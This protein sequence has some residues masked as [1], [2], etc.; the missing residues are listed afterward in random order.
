MA[1]FA[2][3]SKSSASIILFSSSLSALPPRPASPKN[4]LSSLSS[5]CRRSPRC[6]VGVPWGQLTITCHIF[7]ILFIC[8]SPIMLCP[9]V[10]LPGVPDHI[11][12]WPWHR[13]PAA[14][15]GWPAPPVV[16]SPGPPPGRRPACGS[17]TAWR[18]HSPWRGV[19][20]Y[21]NTYNTNNNLFILGRWLLRRVLGLLLDD[22]HH[23]GA[24]HRGLGCLGLELLL[25]LQDLQVLESKGFY[26]LLSSRV[27]ID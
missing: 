9:E 7:I 15:W 10:S 19:F 8:R 21:L 5:W 2:S 24:R 13:G 14:P 22:L 17:R 11:W 6:R 16:P 26:I 23:A 25:A 3:K 4:S 18:S 1:R 20:R 12:G 27:N